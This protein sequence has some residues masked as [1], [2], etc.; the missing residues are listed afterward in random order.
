LGRTKD[1]KNGSALP[2]CFNAQHLS[3]AQRIKNCSGLYTSVKN[4]LIQSWRYKTLSGFLLDPR[5]RWCIPLVN[6]KGQSLSDLSTKRCLFEMD[7]N[8]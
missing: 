4:I 7:Q 1:F 8:L 3:V 2:F 6:L 5:W